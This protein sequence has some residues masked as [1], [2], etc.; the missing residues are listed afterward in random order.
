MTCSSLLKSR[1]R[2]GWVHDYAARSPRCLGSVFLEVL[3]SLA[4]WPAVNMTQEGW[5]HH[6]GASML[7][8]YQFIYLPMTKLWLKMIVALKFKEIF[9]TKQRQRDTE[10]KPSLLSGWLLMLES[11]ALQ[12]RATLRPN[13]E[14]GRQ[15]SSLFD[16]PGTHQPQGKVKDIKFRPASLEPCPP[17]LGNHAGRTLMHGLA[18]GT[19]APGS[20]YKSTWA[21]HSAYEWWQPSYH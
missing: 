21:S 9:T 2:E 12:E 13:A 17:L 14:Q 20:V 10:K 8:L 7:R 3:G 19:R 18:R 11:W 1:V 4:A 15:N 6:S 16:S 5:D